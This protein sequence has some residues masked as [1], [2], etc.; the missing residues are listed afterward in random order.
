MRP[1]RFGQIRRSADGAALG[2]MAGQR[3][4]PLATKETPIMPTKVR[5]KPLNQQ[6]IVIT[7]AS[8]GI[9]LSTARMAAQQGAKLVLAARSEAAL[10][11]LEE[12]IN[13]AGGEALA[14]IADVGKQEDVQHIADAA[15]TRFGGFD[16]WI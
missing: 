15:I 16:T 1:Q 10:R 8:S 14:V 4:H 6:V 2:M 9:G 5:L 12:E 3:T 11:Q 13:A 7:G